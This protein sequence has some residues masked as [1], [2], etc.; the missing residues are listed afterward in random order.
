MNAVKALGPYWP[1]I[2]DMTRHRLKKVSIRYFPSCVENTELVKSYNCLWVWPAESI[3]SGCVFQY[4]SK[5]LS[6][7]NDNDERN[8]Y[9]NT[10]IK[11]PLQI[12]HQVLNKTAAKIWSG[13]NFFRFAFAVIALASRVIKILVLH[14]NDVTDSYWP[15]CI[16]TVDQ[17]VVMDMQKR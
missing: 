3:V 17:A 6:S 5:V 12:I 14:G 9:S 15:P 13:N 11:F 4:F 1:Y 10:L 2:Y 8:N 16:T 7:K